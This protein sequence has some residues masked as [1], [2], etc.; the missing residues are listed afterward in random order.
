[1]ISCIFLSEVRYNILGSLD[2]IPASCRNSARLVESYAYV[3]WLS[4]YGKQE[5]S[6]C[7]M[8]GFELGVSHLA[9]QLY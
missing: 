3:S 1:M 5:G 2:A 7:R 4:G 6:Y 9:L 8:K